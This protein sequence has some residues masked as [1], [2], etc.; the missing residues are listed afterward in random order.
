[1]ALK[2]HSPAEKLPPTSR[3]E[4]FARFARQD[5]D[6]WL[7]HAETLRARLAF[8]EARARQC[9]AQAKSFEAAAAR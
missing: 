7:A 5:R 4:A 9:E 1:M 2:L 3:A 8:V 6:I